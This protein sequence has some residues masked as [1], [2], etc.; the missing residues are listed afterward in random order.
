MENAE[1]ILFYDGECGLCAKSVQWCL[2]HDHRGQLRFAPLQGATYAALDFANKPSDMETVVLFD[3]GTL[4]VRGDAVLG[5]LRRVGGGWSVL[6][7]L[8]RGV[9]RFLRDALYRFIARRRH[10]W[11]DKNDRCRLPT[12][13]ESA[14]FLA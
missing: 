5:L 3:S 2:D 1:P 11:F 13:G 6:G 12:A 9:P 14:R 7:V 4:L 10:A 8:G